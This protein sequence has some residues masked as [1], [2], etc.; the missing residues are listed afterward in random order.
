MT[1]ILKRDNQVIRYNN[2]PV[3][4]VTHKSSLWQNSYRRDVA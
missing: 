1:N 2:G 4:K 3:D